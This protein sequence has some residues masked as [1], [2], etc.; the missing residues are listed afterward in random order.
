VDISVIIPVCDEEENLEILST[1]LKSVLDKLQ[2]DY[3]I[4]FID[5][6]STDRS[7]QVLKNLAK[8]NSG[9]KLIKFRKNYGKTAAIAAGVKASNG[10]YIVT[11][12]GDLQNDPEDIPLMLQKID[13]GYDVV[14]GWRQNRKDNPL[15][16]NFPSVVANKII[17][18]MTGV[19]LRDNGCFLKVFRAETLKDISLYGEMHRFIVPLACME[20]AKVLEVPVKHHSRIHGHSK[21]NV[22]K[23]FQV[24][25]DLLT[26][27]FFKN[28]IT[29]PL[30]IFGILSFVTILLALVFGCF[31]LYKKIFLGNNY[32]LEHI[33]M[34]C[35]FTFTGLQ[36]IS[37]G[38]IAEILVRIYHSSSK[39]NDA[40]KIKEQVNIV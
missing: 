25:L 15:L 12:D 17:S 32:I 16:T 31:A 21:Y 36:F 9:I 35:L 1:K 8:N 24:V 11:I 34:V 27:L 23:T 10:N 2:K 33:M 5:D 14:S 22:T 29:K 6:G 18:F 20:G 13:H 38:I 4:I 40:Y 19:K 30:H 7:Y 28:F 37:I 26:V 3:E 39:N